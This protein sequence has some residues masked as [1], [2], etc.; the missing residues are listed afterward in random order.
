MT[1]GEPVE[2]EATPRRRRIIGVVERKHG[3]HRERHEQENEER[4]DV[5][6]GG[7]AGRGG[8]RQRRNHARRITSP[9]RW[10]VSLSP[11]QTISVDSTS[12]RKPNAAPCSQLNRVMNCV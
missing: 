5:A 6:G 7:D 11:A 3:D 10:P 8:A 4:G 2:R 1:A 12:S 9:S